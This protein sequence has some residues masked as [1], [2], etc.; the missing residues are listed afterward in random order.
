MSENFPSPF[1]TA[2]QAVLMELQNAGI[3]LARSGGDVIVN[4]SATRGIS[5]EAMQSLGNAPMIQSICSDPEAEPFVLVFGFGVGPTLQEVRYAR[6]LE[7][8]RPTSGGALL[9]PNNEI[10][11]AKRRASINLVL[12]QLG[13]VLE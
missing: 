13:T 5:A 8:G 1:E 10:L 12:G 2:G 9:Y 6:I 11:S 4:T 3:P 7:G